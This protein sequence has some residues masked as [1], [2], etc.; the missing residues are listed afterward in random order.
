MTELAEDGLGAFTVMKLNQKQRYGL[1]AV[2][3]VLEMGNVRCV[4]KTEIAENL[5]F[6]SNGF[7]GTVDAVDV[8]IARS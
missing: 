5:Y 7:K 1:M 6:E 4:R 3:L 8:V 2:R